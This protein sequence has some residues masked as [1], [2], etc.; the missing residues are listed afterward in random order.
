MYFY[1]D[2][3][4]DARARVS[5]SVATRFQRRVFYNGSALPPTSKIHTVIR[6]LAERALNG[7]GCI[8]G[9]LNPVVLV[10]ELSKDHFIGP[11]NGAH[12]FR[13]PDNQPRSPDCRDRR[14]P[15]PSVLA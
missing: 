4:F 6:P 5:H 3:R 15:I 11:Q 7:A 10:E 2:E 12:Q 8:N 14:L 1:V 13:R 9:P